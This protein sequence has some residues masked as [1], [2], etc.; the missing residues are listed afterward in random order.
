MEKLKWRVYIPEGEKGLRICLRVSAEYTNM[1]DR[2]TDSHPDRHR[3]M[4]QAALMDS[5]ARQ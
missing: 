4:A 3:M 1:T 2:Q 5:I